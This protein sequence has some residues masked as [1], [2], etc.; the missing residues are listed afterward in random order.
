RYYVSV[1]IWSRRQ[2]LYSRSSVKISD[3]TISSYNLDLSITQLFFF[4]RK[5]F[6]LIQKISSPNFSERSQNMV[7]R[8]SQPRIVTANTYQLFLEVCK[9]LSQVHEW[10]NTHV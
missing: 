9:I 6:L 4:A 7:L 1:S 3:F 5:I 10:M 8:T 2:F